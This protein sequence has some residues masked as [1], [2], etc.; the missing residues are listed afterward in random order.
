MWRHV[1]FILCGARLPI[2]SIS[3]P[4]TL[5]MIEVG[6]FLGK[7][8][9]M[10]ME[11]W[12]S[13]FWKP[14]APG[15]TVGSNWV[16]RKISLGNAGST[17]NAATSGR[18]HS[19]NSTAKQ[20]IAPSHTRR[21]ARRFQAFLERKRKAHCDRLVTRSNNIVPLDIHGEWATRFEWEAGETCTRYLCHWSEWKRLLRMKLKTGMTRNLS[22][23][24]EVHLHCKH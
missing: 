3:M 14:V 22:N 1:S 2:T 12:F 18:L 9:R 16:S 19:N 17:S 5:P 11:L 24:Q 21:N 4:S 8:R 15:Y 20:R 23:F 6:H 13:L 7:F 10:V